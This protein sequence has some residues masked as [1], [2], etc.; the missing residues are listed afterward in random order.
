VVIALLIIALWGWYISG[1]TS[2]A[3]W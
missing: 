3:G 1:R 2:K